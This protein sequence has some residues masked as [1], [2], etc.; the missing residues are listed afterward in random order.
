MYR[1]CSYRLINL[2]YMYVRMF[3]HW[4]DE[5]LMNAWVYICR[6]FVKT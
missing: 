2:V 4:H 3:E 1:Q 6:L 5:D